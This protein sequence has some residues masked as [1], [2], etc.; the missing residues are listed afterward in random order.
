MRNKNDRKTFPVT[1]INHKMTEQP[2]YN[3]RARDLRQKMT[4]EELILWDKLRNRRFYNLKFLRQHPVIYDATHKE[5]LYFIADFYCAEKKAIIE[6]DGKIH[7]FRK[8]RDDDRDEILR[9]LNFNVLRLK[10]EEIDNIN[11]V[12]DK[13]KSFIFE[14]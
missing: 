2:K 12:M 5:P 4:V 3:I 1:G 6:L 11:L 13:I 9:S 10:N 14:C 8:S 7:D